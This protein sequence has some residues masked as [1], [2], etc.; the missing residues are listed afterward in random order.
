M[1]AHS[2]ILLNRQNF[3]HWLLHAHNVNYVRQTEIH[4]AEQLALYASVFE[5]EVTIE[6]LKDKNHQIPVKIMQ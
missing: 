4:T 5:A 3:F 2:H 6:K 1:L